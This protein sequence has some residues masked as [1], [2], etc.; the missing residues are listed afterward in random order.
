M[1]R[2]RVVGVENHNTLIPSA[3]HVDIDHQ[4]HLG[5]VEGRMLGG[6][7]RPPEPGLLAAEK[8]EHRS[9][10]R[11][12]VSCVAC[13]VEQGCNSDGIVVGSR[14]EHRVAHRTKVVVMGG[15]D[16]HR[17]HFARHISVDILSRIVWY[18]LR[19]K[20]AVEFF[21]IARHR[22]GKDL[23]VGIAMHMVATSRRIGTQ[24]LHSYDDT[25]GIERVTEVYLAYRLIESLAFGII[26]GAE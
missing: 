21:C 24:S 23:Y 5:K 9:V 11:L 16:N 3:E 7:L 1:S 20:A 14:E 4:P 12:A 19:E 22:R 13:D 2:L 6:I 8:A 10:V 18:I 26:T 25:L 17:I 15:I